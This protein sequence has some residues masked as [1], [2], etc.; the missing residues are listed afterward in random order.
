MAGGG[1]KSVGGLSEYLVCFEHI[2]DDMFKSELAMKHKFLK[3]SFKRLIGTAGALVIF[4]WLVAGVPKAAAQQSS[5]PVVLENRNI[6]SDNWQ[7]AKGKFQSSDDTN[8]QILGYASAASINKEEQLSFYVS[9]NPTQTYS[10]DIYRMGW[11]GGKTARLMAIS[12]A[13]AGYPQIDCPIDTVSGLTECN[14]TASYSFTIPISWTSGVYLAVLTN[15]DKFRSHITFVVRDDQRVA[16]F[17]YQQP[18]LTYAAYNNFPNNRTTG[19]SLYEYSSYGRN[20]L[21]ESTRAVKVSLN[22]PSAISPF[23]GDRWGVGGA[24]W[25]IYLVWWLEKMGYDINYSTDIDTHTHGSRL[26]KY[27]AVIIPGHDEYWTREM[28]NAFVQARDSG[29]SITNIGANNA[30]W[31]T[32][33]ESSSA[34]V[35][36]R[37]VVCYRYANLDP[38][39]DNSLKTIRF[40]EVGLPEQTLLGIQYS[41]FNEHGRNTDFVVTDTSHWA[42]EGAT[43][44]ANGARDI[45]GNEIDRIHSEFAMPISTTYKILAT[46]PFTIDKGLPDYSQATIYQAPSK[47][48]VFS[49]G[50]LSWSWALGRPRFEDVSVQRLTQNI[51]DHIAGVVR[52]PSIAIKLDDTLANSLEMSKTLSQDTNSKTVSSV[53]RS[54]VWSFR[55]IDLVAIAAVIGLFVLIGVRFARYLRVIRRK[56]RAKRYLESKFLDN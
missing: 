8:R 22:R 35:V 43:F 56:K 4:L 48:L 37:T 41:G 44:D 52:A 29:V 24:V 39:P 3:K 11:Y 55:L 51:F 49:T 14:W 5:N 38:E 7:I 1:E 17:L 9:V 46:S 13:I 30:Y 53:L 15:E 20:T 18:V 21:A 2:G 36:N 16:Q 40:R 19:K 27:R 6:G 54:S 42:F 50:T 23:S 47:A 34:G 28:F 33:L 25:E 10:I 26:L 32:R 12:G 31:Q 45:V